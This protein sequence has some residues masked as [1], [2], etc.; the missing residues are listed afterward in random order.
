V[1]GD[2]TLEISPPFCRTPRA[3]LVAGLK[4]LRQHGYHLAFDAVG[5]GDLPLAILLDLQPDLLKLDPRLV[6]GLPRDAAAVAV[7]EAFAQLAARTGVQLAAVGVETGDQLLLLRRLGVRLA[8]GNLLAAPR[9]RPGTPAAVSQAATEL[10]ELTPATVGDDPTPPIADLLWA[11]VTLPDSATTEEV[12]AALARAPDANGVVLVDGHNRPRASLDRSRFLLAV[13]ANGHAVPAKRPAIR[14][15][16]PPRTVGRDATALQVLELVGDSGQR[17]GDDVV[18]L[19]RDGRCAGVVRLG[20]VVRYVAEA[21]VEQ[22]TALN[23]LTQLPGTDAVAREIDRRVARAEMFV[24]AWLD[25]D[26][27]K[28]VNDTVGFAAGDDLIRALGQALTDATAN[29]PG[30]RVGHLGGDD[31]LAV[32]SVN[33]IAPLAE[34]LI[35]SMWTVGGLTLSVS[36]A[37]LV[38]GPDTVRSYRDASRL[39]VPLRRQ[40]KAVAGSSW[41]LGRPNTDRV[42]ILRGRARQPTTVS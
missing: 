31:F 8:Q 7:V 36:L 10:I 5:N 25:V 30:V 23:P 40:A 42:E 11:A 13:G 22:A 9:D 35:D 37:A 27:F 1:P 28:T 29:L 17:A 2:V 19:D 38:C 16:D 21:K 15:A 14:L 4:A 41:V 24:V 34:R 20:E 33:E 39:L 3:E 26:S 6:R 32:T 18:V 12:R